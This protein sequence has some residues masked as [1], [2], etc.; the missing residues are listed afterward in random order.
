LNYYSAS[1]LIKSGIVTRISITPT[2]ILHVLKEYS[3]WSCEAAELGVDLLANQ[4]SVSKEAFINRAV[5][6]IARDIAIALVQSLIGMQGDGFNIKENDNNIFVKTIFD[7]N[8]NEYFN[9]KLQIPAPV[10]AIGAPVKA[11]LPKV[12]PWLNMDMEIPEHS[13]VAN[14]FGAATAKLI[15]RVDVLIKPVQYAKGFSVH[16]PWEYRIFDELEIAVN[17]A[18]NSAKEWATN[19]LIKAGSDDPEISIVRRDVIADCN[20][21]GEIFVE[22]VVKIVAVGSPQFD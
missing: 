20:H 18:T 13:E 17:Y 4:L 10:V 15:E 1:R 12:R 7:I 11:W 3:L 14:A 2:D 5:E 19:H 6:Q 9:C 8:A 22:T 21:G 16:L